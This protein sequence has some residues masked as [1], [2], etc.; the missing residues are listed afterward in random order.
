[1]EKKG[2]YNRYYWAELF[3]RR[4]QKYP[5][6]R[7]VPVPMENG[8]VDMDIL[9][10]FR[11]GFHQPYLDRNQKPV[12]EINKMYDDL[13]NEWLLKDRNKNI[14]IDYAKPIRMK[15]RI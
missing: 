13:Y 11:L 7:T 12:E 5:I 10:W 15:E 1:M 8:T 14:K 9:E 3:E 4:K 6:V 2:I